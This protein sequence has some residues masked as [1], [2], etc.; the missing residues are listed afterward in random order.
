MHYNEKYASRGV[1]F[2]TVEYDSRAQMS[3][4]EGGNYEFFIILRA[5]Q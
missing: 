3:T 4:Y 2:S 1:V 5:P